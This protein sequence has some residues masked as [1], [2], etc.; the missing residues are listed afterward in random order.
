[1][2]RAAAVQFNHKAGDK[3]YNLERIRKF[4]KEA[5]QQGVQLI[6]FP[7]MCITGYWHVGNLSR[8]EV[9]QLAE[10]VPDGPSVK[11]LVEMAKT[12]QMIIG[13]GLIEIDSE[14]TLYYSVVVCAVDGTVPNHRMINCFLNVQ[15]ACGP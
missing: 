6:S 2:I 13:A 8:D 15:L 12:Y 5:H 9:S 14:G 4:C 3:A 11:E 10:P 7:E 1:M